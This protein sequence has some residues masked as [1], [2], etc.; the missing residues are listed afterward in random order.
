M[1]LLPKIHDEIYRS[2]HLQQ[3][4]EYPRQYMWPSRVV[5][6]PKQ[7]LELHVLTI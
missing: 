6:D 5:V 1:P 3:R 2:G 4:Q 7:Q